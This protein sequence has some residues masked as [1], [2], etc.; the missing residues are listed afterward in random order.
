VNA[1]EHGLELVQPPWCVHAAAGAASIAIPSTPVAPT[2]KSARAVGKTAL[3]MTATPV[4]VSPLSGADA[5]GKHARPVQTVPVRVHVVIRPFLQ[6]NARSTSGRVQGPGSA[7]PPPTPEFRSGL[8]CRSHPGH[9][10]ALTMAG[11]L[12]SRHTLCQLGD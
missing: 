9:G 5:C 12:G 6:L 10:S 11:V 1:S 4:R 8:P 7:A 3:R 2:A